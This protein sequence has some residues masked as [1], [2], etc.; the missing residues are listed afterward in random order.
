MVI[1]GFVGFLVAAVFKDAVAL[2]VD[3]DD[4][5]KS[6][7]TELNFEEEDPATLPTLDPNA[8]AELRRREALIDQQAAEVDSEV[9]QLQFQRSTPASAPAPKPSSR[10]RRPPKH[11]DCVGAWRPWESC[12]RSC[13]G[14]TR[15]RYFDVETYPSPGG[16]ECPASPQVKKCETK[17]CPVDCEG[18]YGPWGQCSQTC[19]VGLKMRPFIVV[20]AAANGGLPCNQTNKTEVCHRKP[21]EEDCEGRW[22][23]WSTC[24]KPC[25]GGIRK[26]TFHVV[27]EATDG[28][29][30]CPQAP[31]FEKCNLHSCSTDCDGYWDDWGLCTK[32]CGGGVRQRFFTV[33]TPA[34]D[35]GQQCPYKQQE[36]CNMDACPVNCD[37]EWGNW[38]ECSLTC[39]GGSQ[40]KD[41]YVK[42]Q[43]RQ[44]GEQCK[45]PAQTRLC[46]IQPC[47][48]DCEGYWSQPGECSKPCGGGQQTRRFVV[49][50]VQAHGGQPCPKSPEKLACN[51]RPCAVDCR[52]EYSKW[53]NCSKT[54]G[55]GVQKR[56]F[57][58]TRKASNGGK[59]CPESREQQTCNAHDC[60]VDCGG[61]WTTWSAC[62]RSCGGGGVQSREFIVRQP[63]TA[64]GYGCPQ[65]P[66]VQSCGAARCPGTC[67]GSWGA[68]SACPV[69]C[70]G[71]H[72]I[73][74]WVKDTNASIDGEKC[75]SPQMKV[76]NAFDCP[77][78]CEG[79][80]DPWGACSATCGGGTQSRRFTVSKE[81]VQGGRPCPSEPQT[82]RCGKMACPVDCRGD[83]GAAESCSATCGGG[84]AKRHFKV[85]REATHGGKACPESPQL[86]SCNTNACPVKCQ[87]NWS[88]WSGCSVSCGGGTSWRSFSVDVQAAGGREECPHKETKSCN[89]KACP[90]DCIGTWGQWEKC[91]QTCGG[92][93]HVKPFIV[94]QQPANGG[95]ACPA[96]NKTQACKFVPCPV[97]CQGTWEDWSSCTATCG[98]GVKQ[99]RFVPSR[100]PLAGGKQCPEPQKEPCNTRDCADYTSETQ[101]SA[102]PTSG[103]TPKDGQK[104]EPFLADD[105]AREKK[106]EVQEDSSDGDDAVA[107]S[108]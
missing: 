30:R 56:Q 87:G 22:A 7:I 13:G 11:K 80:W 101:G 46:N 54:C 78:D 60:P 15:S 62:S 41:F 96:A 92:G 81:A 16:K 61:Q 108:G 86:V 72:S 8:L 14:G 77:A 89:V 50:K 105:V 65:S 63:A 42:T 51:T 94:K 44:G 12:S 69:S 83:W 32:T 17:P 98:G 99:R 59:E 47:A 20:T 9:G 88:D 57:R 71:G 10:R 48:V 2:R 45:Q 90:V 28:G 104:M 38:S 33:T 27:K 25:G 39:G 6:D 84:Q 36:E 79:L 29:R 64:G 73:R 75:P 35:G 53:S 5:G 19:G 52:G 58:V 23:S 67:P 1:V 43:A 26:R 82:R 85:S 102:E 91:S 21:C 97:D 76:C 70:G 31:D 55:G 49:T 37:G 107:A 100:M 40:V 74:H 93:V 4:E 103:E 66:E 95:K 3:E 34:R 18:Q 68:W 24:S 106:E